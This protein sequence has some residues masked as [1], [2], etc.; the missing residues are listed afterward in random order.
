MPVRANRVA[1]TLARWKTIDFAGARAVDVF[2]RLFPTVTFVDRF[3][4]YRQFTPRSN[5]T[6]RKHRRRCYVAWAVKL[7]STNIWTHLVE[8]KTV[9][10]CY[11]NTNTSSISTLGPRDAY[12][13]L[14]YDYWD[15]KDTSMRNYSTN[16]LVHYPCSNCYFYI[17]M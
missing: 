14:I 12:S 17:R 2:D 13:V 6:N 16:W 7:S 1:N 10:K 4:F 15:C 5:V 9:N 3:W 8:T 11:D